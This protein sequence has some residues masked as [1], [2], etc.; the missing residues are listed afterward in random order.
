MNGASF[1]EGL[2]AGIKA[3][4]MGAFT[5]AAVGGVMG[6][7]KA[8]KMGLDFFATKVRDADVFNKYTTNLMNNDFGDVA[9]SDCGL[10]EDGESLFDKADL[11]ASNDLDQI[12]KTYR[13]A[14]VFSRPGIIGKRM[15]ELFD[16]STNW[17]SNGWNY[18]H[19]EYTKNFYV[20]KAH[21]IRVSVGA[22]STFPIGGVEIFN[23]KVSTIISL[24]YQGYFN[25]PLSFIQF[26]LNSDYAMEIMNYINGR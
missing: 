10:F 4:V 5:G 22:E 15:N 3:G 19:G 21:Y 20:N 18:N 11:S 7:I 24:N 26:K 17:E 16:Y 1:G 25:K 14:Q 13:K 9:C 23:N 8:R 12:Y 2:A 6:G